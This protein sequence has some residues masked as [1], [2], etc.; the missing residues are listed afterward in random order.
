MSGF[1][2]FPEVSDK[3][4]DKGCKRRVSRLS[5]SVQGIKDPF[6]RVPQISVEVL[7]ILR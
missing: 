7:E 4:L 3:V 1:L 6:E 2:E 5:G